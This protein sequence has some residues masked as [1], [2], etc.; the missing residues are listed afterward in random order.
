MTLSIIDKGIVRQ[1]AGLRRLP[2]LL[3]LDLPEASWTQGHEDFHDSG[4]RRMRAPGC[5][6]LI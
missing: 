5:T 3:G 2:A 4:E 1:V 6:E